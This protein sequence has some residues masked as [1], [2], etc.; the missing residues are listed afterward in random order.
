MIYSA[1][2]LSSCTFE[3]ITSVKIGKSPAIVSGFPQIRGTMIGVP[4][5]RILVLWGLYWASTYSGKLPFIPWRSLLKVAA[6]LTCFD[7]DSRRGL[8]CVRTVKMFGVLS[9]VGPLCGG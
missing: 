5:I 8:S 1:L 9:L 2:V 6:A 3:L 4:I 7:P